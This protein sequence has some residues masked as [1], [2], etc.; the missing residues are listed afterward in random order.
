MSKVAPKE[1]VVVAQYGERRI[2]IIP[3]YCK[4]CDICVILCPADVL[5][6]KDFKVHVVDIEACTECM[7][8]EVRCPDFAIEVVQSGKKGKKK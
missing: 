8:C 3:R 4:G 1:E 7:L 2:N 5:E 6:I